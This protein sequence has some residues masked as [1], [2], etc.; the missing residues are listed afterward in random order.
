M[1]LFTDCTISSIE[2]LRRYET[3]ILDVAHTEGIDLETKLE[4]AHREIGVEL[5]SFLLGRGFGFG[6][7]RELTSVLVTEPLLQWHSIHTL[8]I[9]YRDAYHSQMNDRY[10][11]KWNEYARAADR[12]KGLVFDVGVGVAHNP[13]PRPVTP[14]CDMIGGGALAGETYYARIAF[15]NRLGQVGAL[16]QPTVLETEPGT[17]LTVHAPELPANVRGWFVFLG[18]SDSDTRRQNE[19]P[20]GPDSQWILPE[21]GLRSDLPQLGHQHPD[22]YVSRRRDLLRG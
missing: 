9:T 16:S 15:E 18:L 12:A 17:L 19:T 4:L 21:S 10:L 14:N 22:Y 11:G 2:E 7:G 13:V 8:A 5:T 1:A 3:S 6:A 20:L